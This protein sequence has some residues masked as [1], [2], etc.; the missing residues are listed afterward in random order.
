MTKLRSC[1]T[2]DQVL[3]HRAL[4]PPY[5]TLKAACTPFLYSVRRKTKPSIRTHPC[6]EGNYFSRCHSAHP[7]C[8]SYVESPVMVTHVYAHVHSFCS[9]TLCL[10]AWLPH[11]PASTLTPPY[12]HHSRQGPRDP[13]GRS[14]LNV[15]TRDSSQRPS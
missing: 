12:S 2:R 1:D 15:P 14:E 8:L 9:L 5:S 7:S 4:V 13:Y 6:Q 11:R 3:D 10:S